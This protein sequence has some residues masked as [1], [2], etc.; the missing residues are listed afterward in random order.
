M[1]SNFSEYV[2]ND[3]EKHNMSDEKYVVVGQD[4]IKF[5]RLDE[6]RLRFMYPEQS[7]KFEW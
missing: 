1:T 7:E 2:D 5:Y 6:T 4:Y 3:S